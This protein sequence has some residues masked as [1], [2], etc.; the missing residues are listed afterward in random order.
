MLRA[1]S[2][3][4]LLVVVAVVGIL[5]AL[6]L[7]I[8]AGA[9]ERA[10]QE[11][12]S[13]EL[14]VIATALEQYRA[15]YGAYPQVNDDGVGLLSALSGRLTP[16]GAGDNRR[17]FLTLDGLSVDEGGTRLVDPWE[18]PYFYAPYQSGIRAGYRLY[19]LGKDGRHQAPSV[20]GEIFEN[21][22]ENLDNVMVGR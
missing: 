8:S 22:D 16:S 14:A 11:R 19:S 4:E 17:P 15:A 18:R 20:T 21:A 5:A 9:R 2:L 10:A 12:A 6:T 13:A 1:F 7:S 3:I